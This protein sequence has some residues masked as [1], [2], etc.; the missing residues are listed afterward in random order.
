MFGSDCCCKKP[1]VCSLAGRMKI[2]SVPSGIQYAARRLE[3]FADGVN[4]NECERCRTLAGLVSGRLQYPYLSYSISIS[5]E[6]CIYNWERIVIDEPGGNDLGVCSF[7]LSVPSVI[8]ENTIIV[9]SFIDQLRTNTIYQR[10]VSTLAGYQNSDIWQFRPSD[11]V[12]GS[13]EGCGNI[14]WSVQGDFNP[15]P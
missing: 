14:T 13:G 8:T 10:S 4:F 5:P 6:S 7:R 9:F 3:C 2:L 12:S 15:L 1:V 11:I